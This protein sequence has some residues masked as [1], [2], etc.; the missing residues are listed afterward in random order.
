LT[1]IA[2]KH[3]CIRG[4]RVRARPRPAAGFTM[5]KRSFT[6]GERKRKTPVCCAGVSHLTRAREGSGTATARAVHP[7]ARL[8]RDSRTPEE[9]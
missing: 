2:A 1:P 3:L 5:I 6:P 4:N 8:E 7:L 9:R